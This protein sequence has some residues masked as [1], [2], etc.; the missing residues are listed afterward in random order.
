MLFIVFY[1]KTKGVTKNDATTGSCDPVSLDCF[2]KKE[3]V[4]V[5]SRVSGFKRRLVFVCVVP[6]LFL[7]ICQTYVL[8]GLA[9]VEK[10]GQITS[11]SNTGG[12]DGD[13]KKGVK[14]PK[15]R[16]KDKGN[17][18][19][20][21]NLTGLIWLKN[22]NAFDVR[23][24]EQALSDANTLSSG[25]HGLTDGSK[26]GDWRLPNVKEL[27]SLIDFAYY[28]PA[29]SSASGTS[30]WVNGDA[31]IGVQSSGYWWST[32]NSSNTPN[33]WNVSLYDGDMYAGGKTFTYSVWPV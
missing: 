25:S 21:D 22:A 10:T 6:L 33:A 2:C 17:G 1:N 18:T 14:W 5:R 16:F 31:F 23:T 20:T 7:G 4:M 28:G 24:W 30:Q 9:K 32:T 19:V 8:G 3:G 11:Y 29:L 15:P 13:L 12:E 26:A 27:Q